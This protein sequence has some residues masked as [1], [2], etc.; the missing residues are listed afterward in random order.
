MSARRI[1]PGAGEGRAAIGFRFDGRDFTGR[2]GD[3]IASALL[4]NGVRIVGRSFKYH[5]PRGIFGAWTEEPNALVDVT[6]AGKTTP[7]LRATTEQLVEGMVVKSVNA[8]PTA[9]ADRN[10]FV[11]RFAR[12]IP[13]GFYYKTFLWPDWHRFEP[14]IRAMAGLGRLD[15]DNE[16]AAGSAHV[17]A[18]CDVLVVGA[19]PA[20]LAA[21]R[22]ASADGK[23]VILVDDQPEPGGSLLHRDAEIDGMAGRAWAAACIAELRRAGQGVLAN[24]AAFG[25]YDHNL[26]GVWERRSGVADAQWRIR[27]KAIV[28]ATG[29]IERPLVFADN[30][31]PGVMSA[32]AALAYLRRHDVLVGE[33]IVVATNND[34]AYTV[35]AALRT[36]GANVRIADMRARSLLLRLMVSRCGAAPPSM[37]CMARRGVEAV[38]ISGERV[39]ADCVLVSG[40][41]TPT[42][43]LYCQAKGSC[44]STSNWRPS[45][46]A[47]RWMASAWLAPL[48]APS[49]CRNCWLKRMR[50]VAAPA[51]DRNRPRLMRPMASSRRGRGPAP[52]AGSG[53]TSRTT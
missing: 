49:R 4:A 15:P 12:F 25:I 20:G 3:T 2:D 10:G 17:N 26:V 43:H 6:V 38:T 32:D 41:F 36:A 46:L 44:A 14:R 27:P 50:P 40:G 47:I 1:A 16:A 33:R 29:A 22:S 9:D 51:R 23:R 8:S 37:P 35:A 7:N 30:D 21:A 31:R 19:G 42:V 52:K 53:S 39:A 5:R 24:A 11:D 34:S 18:S 45:F 13:A 48:T 28:L